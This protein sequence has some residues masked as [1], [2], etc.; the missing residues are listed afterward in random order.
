MPGIFWVVSQG[1]WECTGPAV[2][3][4]DFLREACLICTL[5]LEGCTDPK[6]VSRRKIRAWALLPVRQPRANGRH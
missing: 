4:A 2:A 5:V 6:E 3:R 1:A